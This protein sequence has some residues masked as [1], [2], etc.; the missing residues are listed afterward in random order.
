LA[1]IQEAVG[2]LDSRL[3][4]E[5]VRSRTIARRL[6]EGG[7]LPVGSPGLTPTIHREHFLAFVVARAIDPL[8]HQAADRAREYY[9]LTPGGACLHG[10]PASIPTARQRLA[11]LIDMALGDAEQQRHVAESQIEFVTSWPEITITGAGVVERFREV[12][13]LADHW[14]A[15]KHR[16][17]TTINGAALLAAVRDL[18]EDTK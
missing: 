12:G 15:G 6:Q 18:F 1:T 14:A 8:L 3:G 5:P 4:L 11:R 2:V 13:S 9:A 16:Q 10:A 17:S 7:L